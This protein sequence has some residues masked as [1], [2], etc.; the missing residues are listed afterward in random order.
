MK[1]V[2]TKEINFCF[3]VIFF[4]S[5]IIGKSEAKEDFLNYCQNKNI[6]ETK[7]I[8]NN[9]FNNNQNL[10]DWQPI[11][12]SKIDYENGLMYFDSLGE[13]PYLYG[14]LFNSEVSPKEVIVIKLREKAFTKGLGQFFWRTKED[15]GWNEFKSSK[16]KM[17]NDGEWHEY[18]ILLHVK[19]TLLQIRFDPI[20]NI[21]KVQID[22]LKIVKIRFS[23]LH[24]KNIIVRNSKVFL[25]LENESLEN[26]NAQINDKT[27]IIKAQKTEAFE[28]G[29]LKN[30]FNNFNLSIKVKNMDEIKRTVFLYNEKGRDNFFTQKIQDFQVMYSTNGSGLLLK[31]KNKTV[32]AISPIVTCDNQ[33]PNLKLIRNK[34]RVEFSGEDVN[35]KIIP[36]NSQLKIKIDSN[37]YCEGP[38]VKVLGNLEQ[39]LFSGIEF[40]GK[41]ESSSSK[42]DIETDDS[43]RFD[44][45]PY[46][47]T[48]PLM[49][50]ITD[51]A[52]V[53]MLWEDMKLQPTFASPDF[54]NN[55]QDHRMSLK[56]KKIESTIIVNN[57]ALE[58][59]ILS[60][61]N[62]HGLPQLPKQV[63]TSEQ[64]FNLAMQSFNVTLSK[65]PRKQYAEIL[66]TIW[67]MNGNIPELKIFEPGGSHIN[68]ESIY[69]VTGKVKDWL[70]YRKKITYQTIQQQLEDGSFRFNGELAK[71]HYEN[72]ASGFCAAKAKIL[73]EYAKRT[74]DKTALKDGLKAIDY[75]RHF[76]E[77]R[78]A[79]TWEIPLHT[80]DIL[81]SAHLVHSYVLGY[82][83]TGNEKYLTEAR[84]WALKGIPFVY[85]WGEY[86]IMSYATIAV[87]GAS[88]RVGVDWIGRPVQWCGLV[89]AYSLSLLAEYD[90]TLDWL[91]IAR[92]ILLT[93][94]QMQ[95]TDGPFIGGYPDSFDLDR[96]FKIIPAINPSDV[97][98]LRLKLDDKML[99]LYSARNG[100]NVATT[101]FPISKEG[102]NFII[103]AKKGVNYQ[104][105]LNGNKI[106]DIES[107]GIDT[108]EIK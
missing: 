68:N 47:I 19:G 101:V 51:S 30:I 39:G 18:K 42:I 24:I 69:F 38:I 31:L 12:H 7:I 63:R 45:E 107:K 25:Y 6:I 49:S 74:G 60:Y 73:L 15:S 3:F 91:H 26:F 8:Y 28:V 89:Y 5:L 102:D 106:I 41:G 4:L 99:S 52:S 48:M 61:I 86:P 46:K 34:N 66:S 70:N 81:A 88:H 98:I 2:W 36:D 79:Q 76:K 64:Q 27:F 37:R 100:N 35:V 97:I 59:I 83:L 62:K 40:L 16:F 44:P 72:T 94:E 78:G 53:T 32:A 21:G 95:Y 33:I 14:A 43:C 17:I 108:I 57:Q 71:G 90:K 23:P 104:V 9:D 11:H 56:G 54:I 75:I 22:W 80:P 84:K 20:E 10:K 58:D 50:F 67:N 55:T 105:L 82:E 77:P 103:T 87:Y 1:S 13:D 96:Q 65:L 85:L 29:Q 92:G 93:T